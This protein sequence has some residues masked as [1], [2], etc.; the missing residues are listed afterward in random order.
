MLSRPTARLVGLDVLRG[1]AIL[2][3]MLRHARPAVFGTAGLVGVVMFFALSGYLITGLIHRDVER[4]GRLRYGRFYRNRALRLLPALLLLVLVF[5]IVTVLVDPLD[6]S[7]SL[8]SSVLFAL[9][10]TMDLPFVDGSA[11]L[12][13]LWTLAT[14]EQFYL[15]W[16]LLLTLG[17]RMRRI[18]LV[19]IGAVVLVNV[20]IAAS[21]VVMSPSVTDLYTLPTSWAVAMIIGAAV[22]LY[23]PTV[24]RMLHGRALTVAA[25]AS[26]LFVVAMA[27]LPDTK[28]DALTY[29]LMCPAVAVASMVLILRV[30]AWQALPSQILAPLLGLGVISYAAYLWNY[31]MVKWLHA[32]ELPQP[33]LWEIPCTIAAATL[34]WF[35]LERPIMR[36]KTRIDARAHAAVAAE[37]ERS[38]ERELQPLSARVP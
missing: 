33:W 9:T 25:V 27:F 28:S 29:F 26:G 34:S 6:E 21:L 2:L 1:I 3:V 8:G 24:D 14:E 5:A 18:G 32:L 7:D 23:E 35:L 22:K 37:S 20:A 30:K 16:P 10:Y 12:Q 11:A 15:L 38:A 36:W 31:P 19:L 4:F 17:L 13:H